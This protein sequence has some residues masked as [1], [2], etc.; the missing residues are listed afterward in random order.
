MGVL[1]VTPDSFHEGSRAHDLQDVR[2][3]ALRMSEEGADW[4]DIGGESTRPGS[5]SVS[6]EEELAR[7][8]PAI[9]CLSLIHI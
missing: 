7:V 5:K 6:Q 9:E 4:I 2:S 1:N 8:V 3:R